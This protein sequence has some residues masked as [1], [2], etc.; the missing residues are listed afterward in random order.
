[1]RLLVSLIVSAGFAF[2]ANDIYA[3][4]LKAHLESTGTQDRLG[5]HEIMFTA[6]FFGACFSSAL[7][8]QVGPLCKLLSTGFFVLLAVFTFVSF[9]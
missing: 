5:F 3:T 6:L 9:R 2:M 1:M 8:F 4:N 7:S